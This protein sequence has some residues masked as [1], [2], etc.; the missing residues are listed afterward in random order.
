M[1]GG[2]GG[3]GRELGI[4]GGGGGGREGGNRE[5]IGEQKGGGEKTAGRVGVG[6]RE[7]KRWG[8]GK[9]KEIG[10]LRPVNHA[11]YIRANWRERVG[12][13]TG[14]EGDPSMHKTSE[15]VSWRRAELKSLLIG[16]YS[17]STLV[18]PRAGCVAP[19]HTN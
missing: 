7:R 15:S 8:N 10:F 1:G 9:E 11:D 17:K 6:G 18:W 12:K 13:R 4:K 16:M 14:R 19:Q 2:E 3:T 5:R